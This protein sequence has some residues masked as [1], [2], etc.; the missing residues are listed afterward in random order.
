MWVL[1]IEALR[2]GLHPEDR[3]VGGSAAS[4]ETA[5]QPLELGFWVRTFR[6]ASSVR[7]CTRVRGVL[8]LA[9]GAL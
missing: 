5:A 8:P 3:T 2:P 6:E 7:A 9:C 1:R 4:E